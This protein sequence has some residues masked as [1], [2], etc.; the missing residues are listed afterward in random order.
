MDML[1]DDLIH[2]VT[3]HLGNKDRISLS[4]VN[5]TFKE[6][7]PRTLMKVG[8]LVYKKNEKKQAFTLYAKIIELGDDG[9]IMLQYLDLGIDGYGN[10]WPITNQTSFKPSDIKKPNS[11]LPTRLSLASFKDKW[12][13]HYGCN[14]HP[15]TFPN[16]LCKCVYDDVVRGEHIAEYKRR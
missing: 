6:H 5:K 12:L 15:Q 9:T 11:E 1:Q 14:D 3:S 7:T 10:M 16:T 13:P 2:L 8:D 4:Q